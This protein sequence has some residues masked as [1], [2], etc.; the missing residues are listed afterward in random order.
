MYDFLVQIHTGDFLVNLIEK[1]TV[2]FSVKQDRKYTYI[3][4]GFFHRKDWS[5]WP[6]LKVMD[7]HEFDFEGAL[8]V[9]HKTRLLYRILRA[10][11][12]L[13]FLTGDQQIREYY[14]G[15]E[16]GGHAVRPWVAGD[17][18]MSYYDYELVNMNNPKFSKWMFG[19]LKRIWNK[20]GVST[21]DQWGHHARFRGLIWTDPA[22]L[23]E[24][25]KKARL[26]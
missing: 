3:F 2:Y 17:N 15:I 19:D 25:A 23:I 24:K 4:Y 7:E 21:P 12:T 13:Q 11:N 14:I 1:P 26:L 20:H 16:A 5:T 18:Y 9:V 22:K 6:I 8:Y 10:H